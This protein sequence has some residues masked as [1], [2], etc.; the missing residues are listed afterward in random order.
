[1]TFTG[2]DE[3]PLDANLGRWKDMAGHRSFVFAADISPN[4]SDYEAQRRYLDCRLFVW[5]QTKSIQNRKLVPIEIMPPFKF[6]LFSLRKCR[7]DPSSTA[8]L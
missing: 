1:M 5:L 2:V 8:Y 7:I 3:V 4:L 6:V